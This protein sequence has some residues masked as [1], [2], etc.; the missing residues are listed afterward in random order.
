MS[1]T[2]IKYFSYHG[3][4]DPDRLRNNSP[5]ADTK[6]DYII[7]TLNSIGYAVDHISLAGSSMNKFL[8][9]T[10]EE[11]GDNTFRYFASLKPTKSI[12]RVFNRWFMEVQFFLW[13][14]LNI[15][16]NEQI[17]VY[18]SLGYDAIFIKLKKL[19]NIRIIGDIEEI[20]QDVS[21][22]KASQER[23]E[24]RFIE[25]CDK[26]MFPN[27]ILNKRLNKEGK[28]NVVVHGIYKPFEGNPAR[29]EDGRIHVLYAGTFDPNKGG[30]IAAVRCAEY[31]DDRYIVHIAGFGSSDQER[32]LLKEIGIINKNGK[33]I[34][35]HGYLPS[36][37]SDDLMKSCHI[38]LCTQD[39]NSK[40]NLTSFPSKI[41]NYMSNGLVVLSGRNQAIEESR[42]GDMLYY[43]DAQKPQE[44]A[45]AI[46][47]IQDIDSHSAGERLRLLDAQFAHELSKLIES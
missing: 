11:M 32:E 19:K 40:L 37:E 24:Y 22:Q 43:Y 34:V 36:E 47:R 21:R 20:Y 31:L 8:P 2:R 44:M 5:A 10:L 15:K 3:C 46:M 45:N 13:C 16:R 9:A 25:V 23:N 27:T 1:Q 17:L 14:L 18:H 39:P 28:Q 4:Y 26:F 29:F 12:F 42:V 38:G 30:A 33:K 7:K 6:I 41:L 35:Y